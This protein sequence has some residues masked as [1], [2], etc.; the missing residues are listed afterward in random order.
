MLGES[1]CIDA[2]E[3]LDAYNIIVYWEQKQR[4]QQADVRRLVPK[5]VTIKLEN[6]LL[7]VSHVIIGGRV[8][9]FPVGFSGER[10]IPIIPYGSLGKLIV[11]YYHNKHHRDVDTTVAYVRSDAW[12]VKA[13]K[14]ASVIDSKCRIC[15]ENRKKVASQEMGLLPDFRSEMLPCF[16]VT[17]M[18]LFGPYEIR[19][20]CIK[21]GLRV[22][23]KVYGVIFTCPATRAIQ[24][25]I[26][27]DYSTEA[28]IHT[29]RRLMAIRGDVKMIISDPGAQLIGASKELSGWRYGWNKDQLVQFGAE[30]GLQWKTVM[31]SSQHQNGVSEIMI[32]LVKGVRKSLLRAL[33]DTRLSLNE[34][35]TLMWEI[36]NLVNERPIGVL[37]NNQ[38]DCEYLSPNS[39]LLGRC[40]SRISAGPF[41]ANKVFTDD[42]SAVKDRFLL[43]QAITAQ[44]W[45]VWLRNYFPSLLIR[46][47]WHSEKRNLK[48]GDVCILKD[49]NVFR[50]EWR[51]CRVSKVFPDSQGKVRNVEVNVKPRQ[52]GSMDYL[53][54]KPIT[55]NRHVSNI[56]VLVPAEDQK[57]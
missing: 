7:D 47:K 49:P 37:P 41:Q 19:D 52:G 25:D 45:N 10:N 23:K 3:K 44:F 31:A 26:A 32:K 39:L 30:R 33:G 8:K 15:L 29:I 9:N 5:T 57:T 48:V 42:P 24:L 35:N 17:C 1:L 27:V 51:L 20:D 43:V 11:L 4:L 40:S 12:V 13:R 2:S 34:M 55:L 22:F 14:L 53:A 50:S 36:S 38:T 18:D 56:I 46:Q 28:V 54:T 6:Y 16:S 21:K